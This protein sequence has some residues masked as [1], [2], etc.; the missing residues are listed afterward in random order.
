MQCDRGLA[1]S[2]AALNDALIGLAGK[3]WPQG[4]AA[5]LKL[6][7]IDT[8][9]LA[10][11]QRLWLFGRLIANT[12]MHDG[13]LSFRPGLELAPVYD[14]LPMGYAPLRGVELPIKDFAPLLPLPADRAAWLMAVQAAE[15]FWSAASADARITA[16]FRTICSQNAG[17]VR[18]AWQTFTK[19]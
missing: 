13:N 9:C 6:G 17:K 1:G 3:P 15:H 11:L 2:W 8:K 5:L 4:G 10:A 16:D 14:M 19:H 12:D 18:K 7:Y